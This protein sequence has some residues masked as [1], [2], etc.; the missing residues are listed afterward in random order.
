MHELIVGETLKRFALLRRTLFRKRLLPVLYFPTIVT[1]PI[2][3]E[4]VLRNCFAS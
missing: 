1:T 4:I 2:G 3:S